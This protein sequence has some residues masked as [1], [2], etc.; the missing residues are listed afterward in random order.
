MGNSDYIKL[1]NSE[2]PEGKSQNQ[3]VYNH[4]IIEDGQSSL[5][6]SM[7]MKGMTPRGAG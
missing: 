1:E 4:V 5:G 3:S 6:G 2:S 7:M